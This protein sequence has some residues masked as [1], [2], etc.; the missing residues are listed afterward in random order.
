[1]QGI[2]II[3]PF[4]N[5]Y[6]TFDKLY[7]SIKRQESALLSYEIIVVDDCSSA[8]HE[9]NYFEQFPDVK[10]IHL[11]DNRG[12]M[13]A[14]LIGVTK[15][16]YEN[17]LFFDADDEFA[18]SFFQ[19]V[20]PILECDYSFIL[21]CAQKDD[22]TLV[23]KMRDGS[24]ALSESEALACLFLNGKAGYTWC[25]IIRKDLFKG[26]K[27]DAI[28]RMF[29]LEDSL[30]NVLLF[31]RLHHS[32]Y[33]IDKPFVFWHASTNSLSQ[34]AGGSFFDCLC[35]VLKAKKKLVSEYPDV[36]API[37]CES[38]INLWFCNSLCEI[39]CGCLRNKRQKEA[40]VKLKSIRKQNPLWT[41]ISSANFSDY[42]FRTAF[43]LFCYRFH[44]LWLFGIVRS[45]SKIKL[46]FSPNK[47]P[48]NL[49]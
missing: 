47:K 18:P 49:I 26:F 30:L 10:I 39:Y 9:E 21:F 23:A 31:S 11:N 3:I 20:S 33:Y 22:G 13:G 38:I 41:I 24:G 29:Y 6:A 37:K 48:S 28:P 2:S 4:Y 19:S 34:R 35:A 36:F 12:P 44:L 14:R 25:K 1:M 27:T 7:H 32:A 5:A 8:P 42:S 46:F 45:L 15:A 40:R 16:V 17:I 43:F